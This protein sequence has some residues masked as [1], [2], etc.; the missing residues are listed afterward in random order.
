MIK[1]EQAN[2]FI[3]SKKTKKIETKDF[4]GFSEK[5]KVLGLIITQLLKKH[6]RSHYSYNVNIK[7]F[8]EQFGNNP[9]VNP[10]KEIEGKKLAKLLFGEHQAIH[11]PQIWDLILTTPYQNGYSRRSF[12]SRPTETYTTNRIT[13]LQNMYQSGINGYSGMTIL[14]LAQY[15]VYNELYYKNNAYLYATALDHTDTSTPLYQLIKDIFIGEDDIGG[16]TRGLIKG[17]LLTN[18]VKN[19]ELVKDLL[20]AAQRQEGLRQT[21][22]ESLDETSIGALEYFIK[23]ILEH[24]LTRFSS[25]IRAVDTWFGFG[26]EAPKSATI[27]RVLSISLSF[28]EERTLVQ[29]ALQSNDN[30]EVYV[31]LWFLGLNDVDEANLEAINLIENGHK[32]KKILACMFITQTQRTNHKILEWVKTDFGKDLETDYWVLKSIP[33]KPV[34]DQTLF[35]TIKQYGNE[36]PTKGK[37][38]EGQ[39]F[40][41]THYTIKPDHFYN[42]IIAY[43]DDKQ[44]KLLAQDISKIPSEERQTFIRKI[45][46]DHYIWSYR[47]QDN[48]KLPKIDLQKEPWKRDL[49]HQTIKDRNESV[50]STGIQLFESITLADEDIRVLEDLLSRKSKTLRKNTIRLV[51]QQEQQKI[52]SITSNLITSSKIDQRLAALE[53][54]T[55]LHEENRLS[56]YIADTINQYLE[57]PKFSKNEQVFLDKFS[58]NTQEYSFSNGFGV[59]DYNNLKPL[60]TPKLIFNQQKKSLLTNVFS[61]ITSKQNFLFANL[62]DQ[63]KTAKAINALVDLFDT[64]KDFEYEAI[65]KNGYKEIVLLANTIS[66]TN[67]KAHEMPYKEKVNYL[68]LHDIWQNWYEQ[69]KLNDF[70]MLTV[71][72]YC[73]H[74]PKPFKYYDLLIPFV[75][76]YVPD[77][78]E[79]KLSNSS[80]WDSINKKI[81]TI[82]S[83]L[84]DA[85]ADHPTILQFR[86]DVIEDLIARLPDDLKTKVTYKDR[87]SRKETIW[88]DIIEYLGIGVYGVENELQEYNADIQLLERY[89]NIKMFLLAN[90]LTYPKTPES[91]TAIAQINPLSIK[92]TV[93]PAWI[94]INLYNA[95]VLNEDDVMYQMLIN[96]ELLRALDGRFD[97]RSKN[98]EDK[99]LPTDLLEKIKKNLLSIELERGDL[100]TEAS[101][102][103]SNLSK[104]EGSFYLFELLSRLG[105]ETFHR[106]YYWGDNDSKKNTFSSLIKKCI[107]KE[108]E[109]VST[110]LA[111]AQTSKISKKRW[112]ETAIYAPQWAH[113]IEAHLEIK[114][115][116]DAVWWFH[117]HAS[118]YMNAEKETL[119]S[120][121]SS[122]ERS[123]FAQGAIDI[124]WFNDVY[125]DVGKQNWKLLHDAAKYISDGNG[126][127]LVKLYS[128]VML[129]E[130]K[131]RETL[132]K[133][134]DKRDKDYVRALGLIPL[135]KANPQKDL[136]NRYNTLQN[137]LKESKQFGSQRQESEKNAV[138]IAMDNLAR[139]AGYDDS[140]RFS[141]AME[142]EATQKIMKKANVSIDNVIVELFVDEQGKADIKVTKDGKS[143]KSIPAKLKKDK[144]I[145]ALQKNKAY[146]KKQYSRT[147]VS[148]ENA[149]LQE[150]EFSAEE[151]TNIL[152]HP[153]VKAMLSKLVLFD[154]KNKKI[155]FWEQGYLVGID[156]KKLAINDT[157]TFVIA[158]P[159]HLYENVVW[160]LYQKYAF[161]HKLVQPF[162]QIFRELY[163]IT[164]NEIE[165]ATKSER[166]QGHQIQPKKT[167]A[168]LRSRGWTVSHEEGL[169]KVYHKKGYIAT[170]Y[171]MADWYSP[172]DIEAPTLEHI[173]FL[174]R[175][176]YTAIPLQEIDAVTYSEVM[177]D[178]D[179]V[180][181]VA[182]VGGVDP[183]A[184]HSTMQMRAVL[185]R[186]TARLF[187]AENVEIKERHI[188]IKGTLAEYSIHLGSGI[189]SK[190]G[191]QLSIIPVHSQHRGR[192][193][194]PFIDDDPKSAEIISKMKLLSEDN[195]IKDPTIL[196]QINR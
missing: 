119:I 2:A 188:I 22:L 103:M 109:E 157:D 124:N 132:A 6:K 35:D 77:L 75:K 111:Q 179:L 141:W 120:R 25:V 99:K 160:D 96:P 165:T 78:K 135:S 17:L 175:K 191:L 163:V 173:S 84:Y 189:V 9:L 81:Y 30:L 161:D 51:L 143:Q 134:N 67:D 52:I 159:S 169:Q 126:H 57:R 46:P 71:L 90:K 114:H 130:V 153:V 122:I 11:I 97:Y 154:K 82:V 34:I 40:S 14:E 28:F 62:I 144:A 123:D 181:S 183:E 180:V 58:K 44:D 171:A 73:Q 53:I 76:Q 172:A 48:K 50:M 1:S 190:N 106:G 13:Y 93:P 145:V 12:R 38:I 95:G 108:T 54:L 42:F 148:L 27:K 101:P 18:D 177:R 94:T 87:W 89:W 140:I 55:I 185:A 138:G 186:E 64:H 16:V 184:S 176:D 100:P 110:F 128:G 32:E 36:L 150:E 41:W 74:F 43:A 136:L 192:L 167:I 139:N 121:Y 178:I 92:P 63:K 45:F 70:E 151:I 115:L 47:Y 79:L 142:G 164:Q 56:E 155:G 193:F 174:S 196:A 80:S 15:D 149:M 72:H 69:S 88:C 86:L 116:E 127:R 104:I 5:Y 168:L 105:K 29:K 187:K 24:N 146:L 129:G 10:W 59:I 23:I 102:Y 158:H 37:S 33:E 85:F 195:K 147:R 133:I 107:P 152:L 118:D 170:M 125:P 112:I 26:W 3:E 182:H 137:F 83:T 19:W 21:I 91:I 61:K 39:V 8:I 194:L 156:G 60:P 131:I 20:L 117:A 113:W 7:P 65:Y 162:K 98:L 49:I 31:A 66:L 4:N 166:Y 68:P